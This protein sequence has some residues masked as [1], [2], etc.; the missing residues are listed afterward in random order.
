MLERKV[1]GLVVLVGIFAGI[2]G[3][4]FTNLL[5][6]IQHFTFGYNDL[7][8]GVGVAQASGERRVWA[9]LACGL[10]GGIGW[11]L[12]HRYGGKLVEVKDAVKD[13]TKEMPP[14]T[15]LIHSTL[16]IITVAMG[17]PLGREVAPR[18]ATSALITW[19]MRY[20]KLT[21]ENRSLLIA[22]ASGA[23]LA[24]VY[25]S[26]VSA[27]I[28]VL[29]ALLLTWNVRA[30]SSAFIA[31]GIATFVVRLG[32]GDTVQYDMPQPVMIG[33]FAEFA[34][35]IGII[36]G[37]AVVFFD[38]SQA[39]LPKFDRKS[40]KMILL[41]VIA[42]GLVGLMA[43]YFPAI[44]GNG[45]PGNQL[46]FAHLVPWEYGLGLFAAKWA[47]VLL[48]M[49]AGAYG[50]KITPSMMLGST[51][52]LVVAIAWNFA[53]GP[54]SIG[55]SAFLGAVVFL[56]L[57]QKMPLTSS[58]FMLELSRFSVE[59]LFPIALAMGMGMITQAW[60][61]DKI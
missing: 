49:G 11:V 60:L 27:T 43:V 38:K 48:A 56:G 8:F 14:V 23:G 16:Q 5:H 44:L 55:L 26:P 35:L 54:I 1:F 25:N 52:A 50:G 61:K 7:S 51:L 57:A 28:F 33:N 6:V 46:T 58:V 45:K 15:T 37:V 42:F 36:I 13:V 10:V 21:N 39:Y 41:S 19:V 2:V 32:L 12:I 3:I 47:A 22:C 31:C 34:V 40:P 9:L 17:S 29:E 53:I 4:V 59:L 20:V 24:A 18:E 30:L